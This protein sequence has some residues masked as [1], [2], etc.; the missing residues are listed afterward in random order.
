MSTTA[1]TLNQAHADGRHASTH[2][3]DRL[4]WLKAGC[5]GCSPFVHGGDYISRTNSMPYFAVLLKVSF[6]IEAEILRT[7]EAH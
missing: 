4:Y 5:T 2:P 3:A 6:A 7:L 1:Y